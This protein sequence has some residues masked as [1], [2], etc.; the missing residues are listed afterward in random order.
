M[1]NEMTHVP[2]SAQIRLTKTLTGPLL[3]DEETARAFAALILKRL[4]GG[5]EFGSSSRC[6]SSIE[7][8]TGS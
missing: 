4:H 7:E 1:E 2:E 6:A 5:A 3:N 8:Q